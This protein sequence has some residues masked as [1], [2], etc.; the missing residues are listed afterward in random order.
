MACKP[1]LVRQIVA[2]CISL[3]SHFRLAAGPTT[4]MEAEDI[5]F[6]EIPFADYNER[7]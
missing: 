6:A 7:K 5:G 1:T 4:L 3:N 2:V